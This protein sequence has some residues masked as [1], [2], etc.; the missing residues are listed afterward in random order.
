MAAVC[1]TLLVADVAVA[2][3]ACTE[4]TAQPSAKLSQS[5]MKR[6][7]ESTVLASARTIP[8]VIYSAKEVRVIPREVR[9]Q[10]WWRFPTRNRFLR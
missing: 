10:T 6:G 4:I 7:I 2:L 1:R 5:R 9:T 3:D 8:S